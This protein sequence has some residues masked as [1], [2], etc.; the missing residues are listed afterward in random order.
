MQRERAQT[1]AKT[2]E[3]I[4]HR[5]RPRADFVGRHHRM[6]RVD[7]RA[8]RLR[9]QPMARDRDAGRPA[10]RPRQ[11]RFSHASKSTVPG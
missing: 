11:R 2:V 10:R 8:L 7:L 4:P 6:R 1:S 9:D 3:P 5:L